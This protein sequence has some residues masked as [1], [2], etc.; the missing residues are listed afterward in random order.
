MEASTKA[1]EISFLSKNE[2]GAAVIVKHIQTSGGEIIHEGSIKEIELAYPIKKNKKAY[3]GC[4]YANLPGDSIED[5]TNALNLENDILRF[6][7][8]TPPFRK[9]AKEQSAKPRERGAA[10]VAKQTTEKKQAA[11]Q[12]PQESSSIS[13]ELL[14]EKL[15]EILK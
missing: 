1:Y 15:E 7:V 10:T 9:D 13:N 6:L 11:P 5:M 2:G 14:E 3:M 12:K 4:V 8:I